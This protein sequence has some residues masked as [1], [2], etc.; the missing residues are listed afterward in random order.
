MP[1]YSLQIVQRPRRRAVSARYTPNGN[2]AANAAPCD[3]TARRSPI[4]EDPARYS[5]SETACGSSSALGAVTVTTIDVR[6]SP[7]PQRLLT[8]RLFSPLS[9]RRVLCALRP[10]CLGPD[11]RS[12]GAHVDLVLQLPGG[13]LRRDGS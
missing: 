5:T 11:R 13:R 10:A 12:E 8:G 6:P 2:V 1:R 4:F 9:V 3:R 7:A